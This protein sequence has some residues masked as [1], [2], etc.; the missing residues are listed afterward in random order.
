MSTDDFKNSPWCAYA[1][2]K[3]IWKSKDNY[4]T[5]EELAEMDKLNDFEIHPPSHVIMDGN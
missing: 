4:Y 5:A 3:Q 1:D 2:G